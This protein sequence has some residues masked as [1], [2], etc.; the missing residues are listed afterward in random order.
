[1]AETR[2]DPPA[3]LKAISEII[4]RR[5]AY[6]V[7]GFVRDHLLRRETCDIDIAV[8]GDA[9]GLAKKVAENLPGR[10]VLLD[11][12][13]G[14]ARVVFKR[15]KRPVYIDFSGYTTDI[16]EDLGRRDFTINAMAIHLKDFLEGND[17]I[18]DP[19]HGQ[20][21]LRKGYVKGVSPN[22]FKE[23]PSRLLR[24]IRFA[25]QLDYKI[26]VQTQRQIKQDSILIAS[27]PG[28]RV[29][30]E[31]LH[32]L[33]LQC[34]YTAFKYMD[35]L[36]LLGALIPEIDAMKGVEQPRQH[37]W[38]VFNHSLETIGAIEFLLMENDWRYNIAHLQT[39][40]RWT[41]KLVR[42]FNKKV[43][44]GSTRKQILKLAGLIHDIAKPA[45]KT[46]EENGKVRFRDHPRLGAGVAVG[47]LKRLRFSNKEISLAGMLVQQHLRPFQMAHATLPTSRAIYRF[48]RDT[49]GAGIDVLFIALADHLAA[50]GG[51]ID[52]EGWEA[53]NRMFEHIYSEHRRQQRFKRRHKLIDGH[54]LMH[55]YELAQGPLIGRLLSEIDEAQAMGKIHTK[56]E[57]VEFAARKLKSIRLIV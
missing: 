53:A 26:A 40:S 30:E 47:I 51:N 15:H 29:R 35:S 25:F 43:S 17:K 49:Q 19:F 20:G 28:E 39:H 57:A 46:V 10:F 52:E 23:D 1:M 56:A 4:G 11:K 41:E 33:A 50:R 32:V 42:H 6:L 3:L 8:K 9:L 55:I 14:I 16:E 54:D 44:S 31:L 7:G 21:E 5:Q 13:R 24:A 27:V 38:D 18:I 37:Y 36:G 12:S 45:T 48:F 2:P 22:I 34:T